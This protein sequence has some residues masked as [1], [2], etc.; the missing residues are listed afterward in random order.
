M[1]NLATITNNILADSGIDDIN[2]IVSTGS[3]ANPAWITSLAWTKITGAPLGDYLP[4]AGGTMTGQIIE[5][6][7]LLLQVLLLGIAISLMMVEA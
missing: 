7:S 4:L 3:Y 5:L 1:S 2:V 6:P